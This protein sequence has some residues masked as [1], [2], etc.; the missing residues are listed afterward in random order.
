[1]RQELTLRGNH[2]LLTRAN[3]LAKFAAVMLITMVLALSIDLS[4]IHI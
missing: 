4:L 3:P 2:A 1:M